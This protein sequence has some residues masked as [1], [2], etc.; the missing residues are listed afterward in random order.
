MQNFNNYEYSTTVKVQLSAQE[1]QKMY[2]SSS[3]YN[4]IKNGAYQMKYPKLLH[5]L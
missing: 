5:N 2:E 4:L 1:I 3:F